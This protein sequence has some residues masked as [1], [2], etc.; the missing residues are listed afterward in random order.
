MR[1]TAMIPILAGGLVL[2]T[3]GP[4]LA[5]K[6]PKG[7]G[8]GGSSPTGYD[9]ASPQCGGALPSSPLFGIVGVNKGIVYSANP[10][11]ATQYQWATTSTGT[12][13]ARVSFYANTANPGTASTHWPTGQTVNGRFCDGSLN[14]A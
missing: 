1:R 8:G 7:G 2:A 14:A 10:C 9:V 6:P 3:A 11:L 5:R 13:G 12:A 4:A